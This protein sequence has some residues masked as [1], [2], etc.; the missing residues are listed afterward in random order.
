MRFRREY[1][2]AP[3]SRRVVRVMG[4]EPT[5]LAEQDPKSCVYASFT[6]PAAALDSSDLQLSRDRHLTELTGHRTRFATVR[7]I[8]AAGS[9]SAERCHV[10]AMVNE[11]LGEAVPTGRP[12]HSSR[13]C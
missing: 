12:L 5:L 6:T 2:P 3:T 10:D 1:V 8:G 13:P 9:G 11:R 7:V 4:L